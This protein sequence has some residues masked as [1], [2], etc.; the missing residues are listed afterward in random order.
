MWEQFKTP[1][2]SKYKD[3]WKVAANEL[4]W[5]LRS[6]G[7]TSN[8]TVNQNG[9]A[10]IT[11]KFEDQ[12]DLRPSSNGERSMEY[13]VASIILG[14]LYHDIAGANDLMKIKGKWTNSYSK[15]QLDWKA[16][17]TKKIEEAMKKVGEKMQQERLKWI[18]E[19]R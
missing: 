19:T 11:H 14:F 2:S 15:E 9:S 10:V 16:T 18:R 4:T 17:G 1:F 7:V 13:D 12:F 3:T 6:I 8:F 5:L